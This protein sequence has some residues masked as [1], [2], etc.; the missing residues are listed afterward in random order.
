MKKLLFSIVLFTITTLSYGQLLDSTTV[1]FEDFEGSTSVSL[2][3]NITGK[4]WA[5]QTGHPTPACRTLAASGSTSY[6]IGRTITEIAAGKVRMATSAIPLDQYYSHIYLS[7]DHICK[8][9]PLIGDLMKISVEFSDNGI[10]FFDNNEYISPNS[11][12]V[13]YYDS[14]RGSASF[15]DTRG[16]SSSSYYPAWDGTTP[17]NDWWRRELMQIGRVLHNSPNA[18]TATHYRIVF[19]YSTQSQATVSFPGW[20]VDNVKIVHS[21]TEAFPPELSWQPTHYSNLSSFRVNG[22]DNIGPYVIKAKLEDKD[23]VLLDSIRFTYTKN[24]DGIVYSLEKEII[25]QTLNASGHTVNVSWVMPSLCYGDTVWYRIDFQDVHGNASFAERDF[26]PYSSAANV[27]DNDAGLLK[28]YNMPWSFYSDTQYDIEAV[29]HNRSPNYQTDVNIAWS[30]NDS[31]YGSIP[32]WHGSLCMDFT[33]TISLPPAPMFIRPHRLG[34]NEFKAWIVNRNSAADNGILENDTI[35]HRA[36]VCASPLNGSYTMGRDTSDFPT[37]QHFK[38]RLWYCEMTGPVTINIMPGTYESFTFDSVY[39]S[40]SET[41]YVMFQSA[42]G[43]PDDVI[44]ADNTASTVT[45]SAALTIKNTDYFRFNNLTFQGKTSTTSSRGINFTG[46]GCKDI[47]ITNCKINVANNYAGVSNTHVGIGRTTSVTAPSSGNP[48]DVDKIYLKDNTI[49]GG[50]YGIYYTGS[51]NVNTRSML[52]VEGNKITTSYQG[53]YIYYCR[54]AVIEKNS[55]Y[56]L[57]ND[58]SDA[59]KYTGIQLER[60]DS[61]GS[62]SKNKISSKR[63]LYGI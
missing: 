45:T 16:Y 61:V 57:N 36:Y 26:S 22:R 5:P 49:T 38:E 10:A 25:S 50:V 63:T 44:I 32:T 27:T 28:F 48:A 8:A 20:F 23:T 40:M 2:L 52:N 11:A 6:Y 9:S 14:E 62:I 12:A 35:R 54:A 43:N 41:N 30:V 33:D 53:I 29:L 21:N 58:A 31:L 51:S 37:L 46:Q 17:T 34:W 15:D 1:Y 7:F 59:V 55:L 60:V 3:T 19:M 13:D 47:H 24:N 56:S 18:A 42:T 4:N 39:R